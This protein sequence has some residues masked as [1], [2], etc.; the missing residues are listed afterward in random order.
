MNVYT[1]TRAT[2][3]LE[4]ERRGF[5]YWLAACWLAGRRYW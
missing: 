5:W 4:R 2:T 3:Q 1:V